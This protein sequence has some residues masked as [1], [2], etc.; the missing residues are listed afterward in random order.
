MKKKMK[1]QKSTHSK[2]K[3]PN[4]RL[5]KHPV[6]QHKLAIL[7]SKE[8]SPLSFRLIT[9]EISQFMAYE[10]TRNL[11]TRK[12]RIRTPMEHTDVEVVRDS[13][14]VVPVLRAGNAMLNGV[15]RIV[16]FA[17]VGHVGIYRDRL[18]KNTVEYYFRLPLKAKGKRVLVLEPLLASGDTACAAMDRLKDYGVGPITLVTLLAA[19]EGLEKMKKFHPDVEIYTLSVERGLNR[20]GYILPGLG[21]AGERLYGATTW[22]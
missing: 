16:P 7:R 12:L 21:D 9:E 8:T 1:N 18:I 4:L 3:Y 17:S 19:P 10:V 14:I 6:I 22:K 13:L 20:K 5:I 11:K 15:I 2:T